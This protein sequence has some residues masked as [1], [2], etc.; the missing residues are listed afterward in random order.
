VFLF[1]KLRVG[2]RIG[3]RLGVKAG[4]PSSS[5]QFGDGVRIM[6][7]F[8]QIGVRLGIPAFFE[9]L[10]PSILMIHSLS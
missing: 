9:Q 4:I 2:V 3:V 6:F 7:S 1:N 10:Y 5:V 8:E